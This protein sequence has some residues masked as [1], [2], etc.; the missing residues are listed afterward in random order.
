MGDAHRVTYALGVELERTDR[1]PRPR[2][3]SLPARVAVGALA[4]FVA[5]TLVQW[6][7]SAILAVVKFGLVVAVIIAVGVW[8]ISAKSSR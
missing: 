7:L 4:V 6:A 5:I 2:G 8:V 1:S 3:M